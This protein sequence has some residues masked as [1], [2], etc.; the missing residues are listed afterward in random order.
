VRELRE[1]A[2]PALKIIC[3]IL[4][5]LAVYQL[6]GIFIRWNPFRGVVVPELPSL[7]VVTNSPAASG[8]GT[9]LAAQITLKQTN[10]TPH[11]TGTNNGPSVMV[12]NTNL[13]LPST[14]SAQGTNS[15][16]H[17]ELPTE[18]NLT[19]RLEIKVNGTNFTSITNAVNQET[20]HLVATNFAENNAM[21]GSNAAT[22]ITNASPALKMAGM[23]FNPFQPPGK[24][25]GDLPPVVQAR[26]DRIIESE[27]LGP[28]MHPLPQALMGI[29]GDVA[30]LR[31]ANGQTGMV[32]EGDSLGDLK[33]LRIGINRVLVEQGGQKKELTI[34]SGYGSDSLLPKEIPNE[35]KHP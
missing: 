34:F 33:L 29:A 23:N 17:T 15:I 24:R 28:I 10:G 20:N 16:V 22:K 12:A 1:R 14:A 26:I 13:V 8:P 31:S 3:L 21:A 7:A 19:M 2:G 18:T 35:N 32:K 11:L 6:A 25:G 27:I 9:N 4:V 5:M 30:F